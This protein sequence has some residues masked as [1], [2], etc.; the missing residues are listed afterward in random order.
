MQA[1]Y[2]PEM[3][4]PRWQE[5]W[6]RSE[7]YRVVED[8]GR[9]KYYNLEM[10]PYPSGDLHM[11]HVRNYSLGDVMTRY[12][13][14]KGYNVLH[15][16]GW[17]AFGL[18]AENAA[19][20]RN[21]P[22]AQWTWS[23]IDRMRAQLKRLGFSYDWEREVATCAPDYYRWTQWFFLLLHRRGLAY[24][25]KARVNWCP[26]CRTVLA[27]EQVEGGRCWRCHSE[28]EKQER[29]QWFF[30]I[31]AYADR[32]LDDLSRLDGWP[33]RVKAMQANWIGR[34]EGAEVDFQVEGLDET[35][36]VFTTRPDTL[37]GVTYM[38]LAPDHRL[39]EPL[40]QGRPEAEAVRRFA[41]RVRATPEREREH[42]EKEGV[43][44]GAFCINPVNGERV[45]IWVG[46]YVVSEYGT[47]AVMAVPA[48]DPRDL[49]FAR[50]Y[51][52][53]VRVVIRP[54]QGELDEATLSEA[55]VD[56]GVMVRSGPFDGTP[57]QEGKAQVIAYLEERGVGRKTVNYRL[58]D[59]LISRQRYWGAP[60]PMV[61]CPHCGTVPVPEEQ[62]PVLLPAS[63]TDRAGGTSLADDP[64]FVRTTC[65]S[66]GG[67]ARRE[68]DTMDTFMCSS[69]YY[70]RFTS[71]KEA[72][73]PF[74]RAA[75][76]YWMPVD[77][78]T[79]GI[80][81]AIMHLL[82]SRFFT[83]V[84]CDAGLVSFQEPFTRLF[85]QGMVTLGGSAMSKS[86]G[87]VVDPDEIVG[88]YG[89]DTAR[90]FILF[91]APPEND[92]E[93]S[94]A[95]VEGASRFLQRVWRLAAEW[96]PVVERASRLDASVL[97]RN[98]RDVHRTIHETLRKVTGDIEERFSLNTS[99]SALM[100]L[101]NRLY[102]YKEETPAVRPE[103]A[104]EGLE[105]LV[106]MLAPFAPHLAEELWHEAL[107]REGSV[108]QASWPE[109]DPSAL[110]R[111][112][113]E[114]VVQVNG[115]LRD[116]LVVPVDV[117][118]A[119]LREQATALPR[120]QPFIDGRQVQRVIVVPGRLVNVV[121]K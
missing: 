6:A 66:C 58:R 116:R 11:G 84:L 35:I 50:A 109:L 20:Q 70:L 104:R 26:G 75:V 98:E 62:L 65:P 7:L 91:A 12:Y 55:Y 47:G 71:P 43:P 34:S 8:P 39:V 93:W 121:V 117:D 56:P 101:V 118:E 54:P 115:K 107:G 4:E 113:V 111:E 14:M 59:W 100:S 25:G 15:P 16:M 28:V 40:I 21:V 63:L 61:H 96:A 5:A 76:D 32:L 38:V 83:K 42:V 92:L 49:E 1:E 48:H 60:I 24:R 78:Y 64:D 31:T 33:E 23:N 120:V 79:G 119:T 52:L 108:H 89:A 102:Q 57:S 88:K 68:T 77:R 44:T 9:P 105:T 106:L 18:P 30:R 72:D 80:E 45:P 41:E 51:G 112:E 13:R 99:I 27:N 81:H 82:Y 53:P 103:L 85:T 95:G 17:D 37:W 97:D 74:S 73:A 10:F 29:E 94:E 87:N 2:H 114:V 46:N 86:R 36:S 3:I 110:E 19:I 67:P 22:A 90:L 69:W